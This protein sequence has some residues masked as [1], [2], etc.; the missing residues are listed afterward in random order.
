MSDKRR[1]AE[2]ARKLLRQATD[3]GATK[4]EA[5]TFAFKVCRLI[6]DHGL[7]ISDR[8]VEPDFWR[9]VLKEQRDVYQR[10]QASK[11]RPKSRAHGPPRPT[12]KISAITASAAGF[13]S[14][15][16]D[17]YAKG[18]KVG[19]NPVTRKV[20]HLSCWASRGRE[21]DLS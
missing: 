14:M 5:R 18:E 2:L 12:I 17:T 20:G 15:C 3:P 4:E 7:E 13:C 9:Q 19:W 10:A 16:E 6:A 8:P 21:P 1:A 11:A